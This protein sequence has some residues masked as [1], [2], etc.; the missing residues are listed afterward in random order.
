MSQLS[1]GSPIRALI[2]GM[3][4]HL[5]IPDDEILAA[6][7]PIEKFDRDSSDILIQHQ[8]SVLVLLR[9]GEWMFLRRVDRIQSGDPWTSPPF[10]V[11]VSE[12][13]ARHWLKENSFDV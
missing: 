2:A 9:S 11:K 8:S 4:P 3:R 13:E 12:E 1:N 10:I 5:F 6:W 7:G